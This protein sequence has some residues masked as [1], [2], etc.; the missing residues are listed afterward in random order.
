[1]YGRQ[2]R[3]DKTSAGHDGSSAEAMV[4]DNACDAGRPLSSKRVRESLADPRFARGKKISASWSLNLTPS[5]WNVKHWSGD[6]CGEET[7][8]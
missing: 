7:V 8:G 2:R 3:R 5:K 6:S 4:D 1:M